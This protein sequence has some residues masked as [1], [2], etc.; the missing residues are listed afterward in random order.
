VHIGK[1]GAAFMVRGFG[2]GV[3][4]A[5][6]GLFL[7]T[8]RSSQASSIAVLAQNTTTWEASRILRSLNT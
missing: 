4:E 7:V 1:E 5:A 8:T 2:V 6:I 3:C